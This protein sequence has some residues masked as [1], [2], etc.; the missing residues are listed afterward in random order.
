MKI[1]FD[2][3][4]QF[5]YFCIHNHATLTFPERTMIGQTLSH[6]GPGLRHF[7]LDKRLAI[8]LTAWLKPDP[9]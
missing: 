9:I 7:G 1:T 4:P 5:G 6:C 3:T 8:L 2:R